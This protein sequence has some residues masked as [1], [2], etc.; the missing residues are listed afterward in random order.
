MKYIEQMTSTISIHAHEGSAHRR[1]AHVGEAH[2]AASSSAV[3]IFHNGFLGKEERLVLF[4]PCPEF[5]RS[6]AEQAIAAAELLES[7]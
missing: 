2:R 4:S 3:N 6:L 5:W 7:P 1:P